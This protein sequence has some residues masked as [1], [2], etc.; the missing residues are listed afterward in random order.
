MENPPPLTTAR[1]EKDIAGTEN[2]RLLRL[3]TTCGTMEKDITTCG[4]RGDPHHFPEL[5]ELLDGN[6]TRTHHSSRFSS[7]FDE[8]A[9]FPNIE[10][11]YM[12]DYDSLAMNAHAHQLNNNVC[13]YPGI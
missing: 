13:P 6:Y 12:T 7:F 9:R 10:D 11:D 4:I 2:S 1:M 5:S 8:V 3:S